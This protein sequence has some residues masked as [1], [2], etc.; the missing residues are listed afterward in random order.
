MTNG[1]QAEN[2]PTLIQMGDFIKNTFDRA[3][4]TTQPSYFKAVLTVVPASRLLR[5]GEANFQKN[6]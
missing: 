4:K 5:T 2:F 3:V 1:D 6:V